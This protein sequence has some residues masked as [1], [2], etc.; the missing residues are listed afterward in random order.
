MEAT[1]VKKSKGNFLWRLSKKFQYAADQ[2]IP[3]S[4]VFCLILTFLVFILSMIFAEHNPLKLINYWYDGFWTQSTFAFQMGIMTITCAAAATAP[5]VARVMNKM[6][7]WFRKPLGAMVFFMIFGYVTSFINWAFSMIVCPVLAMR[8]AKKVKGLHFPMMVTAGYTCM[9][10]GQCMGPSASVYAVVAGE[11]HALVDVIGVMDQSI[12]CYYPQNVVIWCIVAVLTIVLALFT[13]PPQDEL[14]EFKGGLDDDFE[15][16]KVE[17]VTVA[18]KLNYCRPFMWIVGLAGLVVIIYSF[19]TKGVIKS[20]GVNFIIFLF[21]TINC[22]LYPH[23]REFVAAHK[24]TIPLATDI[25][26]QFPFYGGIAGIMSS[27]GFAAIVVGALVSISTA[28]TLPVWAYISACIVNLFIPSQGGQWI[29]QGPL[30]VSAAIELKADMSLVI[31]AF[32]YG[33]ET[34][35]LLNPLYLIPALAVV[36]MKL[37][38]VWGYCAYLCVFWIVIISILLYAIPFLF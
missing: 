35:N 30:L 36:D 33:D 29:V 38:D 12:T 15:A 23:P 10:L 18:D 27:S 26:I 19:I 24:K 31:N 5:Q 28:R 20:L 14:V 8:L 16:P 22:F 13:R 32:V 17:K 1:T 2:I 34:T 37:K 21:I 4:F 6:S 9:I 3:D 11:S 7:G 25:I